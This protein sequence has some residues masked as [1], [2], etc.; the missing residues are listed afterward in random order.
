MKYLFSVFFVMF[1]LGLVSPAEIPDQLFDIKM[2]LEDV[3]LENGNELTAIITFESFGKVPT[4][5]D[6]KYLVYDEFDNL[7]YERDG[8]IVVEVE[9]VLR[10][11]FED[12]VL[13]PGNYRFVFRT[14]YNV[15]VYDEFTK[16]FV[17][18]EQDSFFNSI[19]FWVVVSL[20]VILGI[21]LFFYIKN[22]D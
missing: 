15:D 22:R 7:V 20:I 1:F 12:L 3:S 14:I 9:E 11:N 19:I 4:P 18:E 13:G 17:I 2:D 10:E 5:V 6:L 16:N 8:Y 21:I